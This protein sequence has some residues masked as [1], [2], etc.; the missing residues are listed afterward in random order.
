MGIEEV[1][2]NLVQSTL[3]ERAT[4]NSLTDTNMNLTTQVEEPTNNISNKDAEMALMQNTISQ[5][6][7]EINTLN[8]KLLFQATKK[9]DTS[10]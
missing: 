5:L 4:V 10:G 9:P 6:Q 8:I 2:V 1:F 3:K 7:G